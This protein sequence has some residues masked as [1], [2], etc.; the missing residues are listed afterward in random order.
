LVEDSLLIQHVLIPTRDEAILDL[1]LTRDDDLVSD[2]VVCGHLGS[3]DHSIL[4][5]SLNCTQ[6]RTSAA[7]NHYDYSRADF[8][9]IA[10]EIRQINRSLVLQPMSTNESWNYLHDLLST[11]VAKYEPTKANHNGK[12]KLMWMTYTAL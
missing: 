6:P 2:I 8:A 12:N 9:A 1:V 10:E 3:S 11:L 4:M 7:H 5:W